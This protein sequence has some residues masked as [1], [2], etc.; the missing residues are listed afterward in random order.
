[1]QKNQQNALYLTVE[2]IQYVTAEKQKLHFLMAQ[3]L[4]KKEANIKNG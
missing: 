3:N 4:P 2:K 1:M